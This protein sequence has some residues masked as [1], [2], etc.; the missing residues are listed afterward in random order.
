MALDLCT[1]CFGEGRNMDKEKRE[2][3]FAEQYVK[4]SSEGGNQRSY[5]DVLTSPTPSING[6][7]QSAA[8]KR[9]LGFL[10]QRLKGN[11]DTSK[12][13]EGTVKQKISALMGTVLTL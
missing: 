7:L 10:N 6:S 3:S 4:T 12:E 8:E 1:L 13:P 11:I 5:V 2:G 9:T